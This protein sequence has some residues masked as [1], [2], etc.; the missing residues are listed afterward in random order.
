MLIWLKRGDIVKGD[1]SVR[2]QVNNANMLNLAQ[3]TD[4]TEENLF[5]KVLSRINFFYT[6]TKN[7]KPIHMDLT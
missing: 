5:L 2:V 1:T 3:Q 7:N 6:K 4:G